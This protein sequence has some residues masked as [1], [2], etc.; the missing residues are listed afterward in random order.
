MS[1]AVTTLILSSADLARLFQGRMSVAQVL[2]NMTTTGAGA[3][4]GSVG[5]VVG[6]AAGAGVGS[7][8]PWIG[9]RLG[10]LIGGVSGALLCASGASKAASAALHT[11]IEDDA[12][13]MLRILEKSF[14]ELAHEYVLGPK[15]AGSVIDRFIE[16][17]DL[18]VKLRDMYASDDRS[19]FATKWLRPLVQQQA[20][21]RERITLPP[22]EVLLQS[23]RSATTP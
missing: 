21:E 11:F 8:I 13:A 15:D 20:R 1:G 18:P 4:G 9:P 16:A 22:E 7:A 19:R 12:Q 10:R 14:G 23:I 5:W 2:K 6:S 17:N 3:V